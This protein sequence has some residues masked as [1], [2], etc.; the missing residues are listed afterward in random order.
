MRRR[1]LGL[2]RCRRF[3]RRPPVPVGGHPAR[4]WLCMRFALSYRVGEDSL[5]ERVFGLFHERGSTVVED[6]I[7]TSGPSI[8][9]YARQRGGNRVRAEVAPGRA[10][11]VRMRAGTASSMA[12][13]SSAMASV[14]M[15]R[16]WSCHSPLASTTK[17]PISGRWPLPCVA[18][19]DWRTLSRRRSLRAQHGEGFR[20]D[21][22]TGHRPRA[23]G[24]AEE[25]AHGPARQ[26][27]RT[28]RAGVVRG[29]PDRASVLGWGTQA[30]GAAPAPPDA[31]PPG[32]GAAARS[33]RGWRGGP[34]LRPTWRKGR[35][36]RPDTPEA[37][38][39]RT[40]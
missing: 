24:R 16:C 29:G 21:P 38:P 3:V 7:A 2:S 14:C 6:R 15:W 8:R 36:V 1:S 10:A 20:S 17:A 28:G 4:V 19:F 11:T 31:G 13:V 9:E 33:G 23:S 32:A 34:G 22:V 12:G 39:S 35:A 30:L 18:G 27:S 5:A 26:A 37:C 40:R 25:G